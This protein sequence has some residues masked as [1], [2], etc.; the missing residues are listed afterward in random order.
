MFG[1]VLRT[2]V[3]SVSVI[4]AVA[5]AVVALAVMGVVIAVGARSAP[6][7]TVSG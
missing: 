3:V 2:T 5:L 7:I 1:A 6:F 4:V